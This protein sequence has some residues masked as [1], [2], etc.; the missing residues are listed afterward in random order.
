MFNLKEF[1]CRDMPKPVSRRENHDSQK[2]L[3]RGIVANIS[4]GNVSLQQGNF[5]T[6]NDLERLRAENKKHDFCGK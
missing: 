2:R 5:I 1:I 4:R 6:T 3:V